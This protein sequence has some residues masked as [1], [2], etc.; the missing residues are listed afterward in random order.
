VILPLALLALGALD[1]IRLRAGG[2][3]WGGGVVVGLCLVLAVLGRAEQLQGLQN[4]RV[5]EILRVDRL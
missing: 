2:I 4:L 1:L 5:P 3:T